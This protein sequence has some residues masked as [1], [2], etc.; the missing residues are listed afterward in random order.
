MKV[1]S[2]RQAA[3]SH[4]RPNRAAVEIGHFSRPFCVWGPSKI[5][6]S[7]RRFAP[8]KVLEGTRAR[9]QSS[10]RV[11]ELCW[12][13]DA[14]MLSQVALR[15]LVFLGRKFG[16]GTK[17]VPRTVPILPDFETVPKPSR[18][19]PE[20]VP[21]P[22]RNRPETLFFVLLLFAVCCLLF[23]LWLFALCFLRDARVQLGV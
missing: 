9:R 3:S 18:N 1:G 7:I 17:S 16:L 5:G 21:K 12:R 8:T 10:S 14:Q 11:R 4:S 2:D 22:S 6:A 20:T 19:R 13:S 15:S 23:V